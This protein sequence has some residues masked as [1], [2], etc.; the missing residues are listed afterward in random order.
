MVAFVWVIF[1]LLDYSF[2]QVKLS[3]EYRF[4]VPGL[5]DNQP[6]L[7]NQGS[8][9]IVLA[10]Y[11]TELLDHSLSATP[12]DFDIMPGSGNH[13]RLD[14]DGYFVALGY[15]TDLGCPLQIRDGY[16]KESCSNARYDLLGRS[17]NPESYTDLKIPHYQWNKNFTALTLY[18]D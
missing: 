1:V 12:S 3:E 7:L 2:N 15:G 16:F 8:M 10:R 13:Q 6:L 17:Q 18:Q 5:T 9:L 14:A 4:K 11:N